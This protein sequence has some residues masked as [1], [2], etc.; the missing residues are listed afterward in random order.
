MKRIIPEIF[1]ENCKDAL[2]FYKEVFGGEIKNV[3]LAD[4]KPMFKGLE[5]KIIHSELHINDDCIM[6][7]V[8]ILG[9]NHKRQNGSLVLELENEEEINRLYSAL[10]K[11]GSVQFELQKTFWGAYHAVV[12]DLYG[13]TWGLNYSAN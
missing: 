11:N 13:N 8:D 4:G 6:Y 5:G 10:S 1:I 2:E 12:T 9:D 3:Q 7:L